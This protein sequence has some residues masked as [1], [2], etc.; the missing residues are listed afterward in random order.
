MNR[1]RLLIVLVTAGSLRQGRTIARAILRAKL[2]ACVNII[3]RIESHYWWQGKMEHG[4][5]VLLVIK[6][7]RRHFRRLAKAV[8]S[9]HSY[10]TPE[11]IALP[12][13]VAEE[14]YRR[15]WRDSLG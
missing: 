9:E 4:A 15:W 3:P 8:R 14:R 11:I 13:A 1:E 5:E 12:L 7:S 6:S 2:A 10:S